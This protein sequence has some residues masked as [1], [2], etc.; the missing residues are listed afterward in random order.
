[1]EPAPD[2]GPAPDATPDLAAAQAAATEDDPWA[3]DLTA[4]QV[5]SATYWRRRLVALLIG[6]AVLTVLVWAV[7]GA[8]HGS[9]PGQA[10]S[11]RGRSSA[12]PGGTQRDKDGNRS[13]RRNARHTGGGSHPA[14]GGT[15][16]ALSGSAPGRAQTASAGAGHLGMLSGIVDV[17]SMPGPRQPDGTTAH[18]TPPRQSVA[19]A[20]EHRAVARAP[21]HRAVARAPEHR[22][23]ARP[24]EHRAVAHRPE[25][26]SVVPAPGPH[27]AACA[28]GDVVLSLASPR[29]WYQRG[30]WPLF[31]VA[32]V[33]TGN[34]P[35]RLNMGARFATVVV[36]SGR[37]RIWG[38][39]DCVHGTGSQLVTLSRGMPAVRWIYWDRATSAP[40]CRPP[41]WT[42][43]QGAY[44]AIAFDGQLSS[45]VMVFM[46]D[47]PGTA[48]P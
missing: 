45:Q 7:S 41:R 12:G 16:Q 11:H 19:G 37:T 36:T 20:P 5:S 27:V 9:R 47:R 23:V 33:S 46:L 38:S 1:M 34:R 30:R 32:A 31:G 22:A 35:C 48:L 4:A 13:G 44:T 25:H 21:E 15:P 39:A 40:G 29:I 24:P 14:P 42:V 17:L 10:P 43:P 2:S 3:D 26:R 18:R 8:L 6:I 28:R